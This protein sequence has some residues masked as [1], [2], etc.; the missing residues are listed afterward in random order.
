[1]ARLLFAE[2]SLCSGQRVLELGSGGLG[3][4]VDL[5][6]GA[7][8]PGPPPQAHGPPPSVWPSSL[9]P[10]TVH[11]SIYAGLGIGALAA[12]AAGA[13]IVLATDLEPTS[14]AFVQ[15]SAADNRPDATQLR[16]A[17]WDWT[18]D[19]PPAV[20]SE[21]P[22][23]LVMAGD[24]LYAADHVPRLVHILSSPELLRPGGLLVATDSC[25]RAYED[26]HSQQLRG[27]LAR[28]GFHE[29]RCEEVQL[30]ASNTPIEE[31]ADAASGGLRVRLIVLA[32]SRFRPTAT[33][34]S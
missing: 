19:A 9:R 10:P 13:S 25:E 24:C 17:V 26:S 18:N 29:R 16:T 1:M 32:K 20:A 28:A 3:R 33:A 2:P 7:A 6:R 23:D 14:L 8:A 22:Y 34:G 4:P 15:Q 27:R 30:D 11:V 12:A 31:G 21:G 5:A